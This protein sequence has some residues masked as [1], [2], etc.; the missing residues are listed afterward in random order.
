VGLWPGAHSHL[1]STRWWNQKHPLSYAK[2]LAE[3]VSPAVGREFLSPETQR[4]ERVLL[5]SR[6]S[7]GMSIPELLEIQPQ[8]KQVIPDLI[9]D[10]L[11]VGESAIQGRLILTLRGRLLADAVV[12]K[13][14]D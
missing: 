10:G 8:A 1:G 7:S 4:L 12:R 6:T 9:A 11:I 14:T 13:L 3:F 2:K 5:E